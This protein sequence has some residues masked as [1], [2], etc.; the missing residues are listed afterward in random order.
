MVVLHRQKLTDFHDSS[1][2][3]AGLTNEAYSLALAQD[4]A[5]RFAQALLIDIYTGAQGSAEV[6][7]LD[8]HENVFVDTATAVDQVDMTTDILQGAK[9]RMTDQLETLDVAVCTSKQWN[10]LRIEHLTDANF[11]VP[12][13]VGDLT[14]GILF[15]NVLGMFFIVDDQLPTTTGVNATRQDALLFRSR[16]RNIAGV[17]PI[18]ISMQRDLEIIDQFVLGE[19]QR[20]NQRQGFASWSFGVRGASYDDTAGGANPNAAALGLSTNWD[21]TNADDDEQHG[22]VQLSTN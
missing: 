20:R 21:K 16:S 7:T 11:V 15:R 1:T 6:A 5:A 14:R 18:S 19:Q 22:V 10:D 13:V 12:N 8:H 9:F 3:R 4:M 2:Q 17:A